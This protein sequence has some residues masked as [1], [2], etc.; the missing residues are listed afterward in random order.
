MVERIRRPVGTACS[1]ISSVSNK[2]TGVPLRAVRPRLA[3]ETQEQVADSL[4]SAQRQPAPSLMLSPVVDEMTPL[5]QGLQVL[6][7]ILGRIMVEV[8]AGEHNP[9]RVAG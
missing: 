2:P 4:A 3:V 6:R 9:G 1:A 8:G 7:P 5:A